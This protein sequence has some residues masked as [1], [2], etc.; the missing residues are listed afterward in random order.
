[1]TYNL[2]D[3]DDQVVDTKATS[4]DGTVTFFVISFGDYT[5]VETATSSGYNLL[6]YPIKVTIPLVLTSGK[7]DEENS[8][9][10][11]A[12]YDK[13]TDS[14][15][16][17]AMGYDITDDTTFVMPTAGVNNFTAGVL[18]VL[19]GVWMMYRRRKGLIK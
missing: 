18:I 12:F 11:Q 1:M 2:Y 14:Y 6:I 17:F 15:I 3:A 8:D 7:A 4:E 10:T 13:D 16:F 9:T 19:A 5:I